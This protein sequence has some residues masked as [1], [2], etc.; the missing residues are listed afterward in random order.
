[1]LPLAGVVLKT[2]NS[3]YYGFQRKISDIHHTI[4]LLG[5][6][7]LYQLIVAEGLRRTMPNMKIFQELHHHCM[8]ISQIAFAL[9]AEKHIGKPSQMS[10]IG[11]MHDLGWILIV[12]I[13]RQ[14]PKLSNLIDLI[15]PPK[16]GGLLLKSWNLPELVWKSIEFQSY[17]E[18]TP[19][20]NI[21]E[22]VRSIVAMLYI[23][24]LCY[25]NFNGKAEDE[26]SIVFFPEYKDLLNLEKYSL[27]D[28]SQEII[29]PALRK[30]MTT[31]PASLRNLIQKQGA[32]VQQ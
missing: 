1:M 30:K 8:V 18:F 2:I 31:L 12:L 23:A 21:P 4:M 11:L 25:E 6:D 22:D 32:K 14:N 28:I 26:L 10:T 17:P 3:S 29:L 27:W 16:I 13:K 9:S 24:H 5:F 15:D 19:P 7:E 20:N